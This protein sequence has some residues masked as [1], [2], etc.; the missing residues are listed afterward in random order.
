MPV[1]SVAMGEGRRSSAGRTKKSTG[2]SISLRSASVLIAANCAM[3]LRRGSVL[4]VS[5]S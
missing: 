5:R 1:T 4:K 2:S 3:R